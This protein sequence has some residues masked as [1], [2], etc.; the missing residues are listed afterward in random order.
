M[1]V[2]KG[3]EQ[4]EH[5]V[6]LNNSQAQFCL[7]E[8][9]ACLWNVKTDTKQAGLKVWDGFYEKNDEPKAR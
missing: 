4:G 8:M 3:T 6:L 5:S 2:R 7:L 1:D 9:C